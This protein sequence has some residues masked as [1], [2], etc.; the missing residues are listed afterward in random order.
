M[1]ISAEDRLVAAALALD[2]AFE[3]RRAFEDAAVVR[4]FVLACRAMR[5]VDRTGEMESDAD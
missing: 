5:D 3:L 2:D 4:E 1:A